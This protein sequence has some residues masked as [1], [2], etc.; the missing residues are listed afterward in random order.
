MFLGSLNTKSTKTPLWDKT[1]DEKLKMLLWTEAQYQNQ[2]LFFVQNFILSVAVK[3][4][5]KQNFVNER[6]SNLFLKFLD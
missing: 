4:S 3:W 1:F 6:V 5:V 2:D